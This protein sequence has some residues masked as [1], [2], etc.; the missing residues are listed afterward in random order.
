MLGLSPRSN[1][2]L[3]DRYKKCRKEITAKIGFEPELNQFRWTPKPKNPK[4]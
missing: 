2:P 4:N 3:S 1:L